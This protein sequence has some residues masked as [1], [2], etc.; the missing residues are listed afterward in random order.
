V[1]EARRPAPLGE[2]GGARL[3]EVGVEVN[4]NSCLYRSPV[5]WAFPRLEALTAGP[6]FLEVGRGPYRVPAS[7]NR[8][9]EAGT[10]K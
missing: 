3:G 10:L 4:P 1:R 2:L 7:E 8:F 5:E 6:P 9:T